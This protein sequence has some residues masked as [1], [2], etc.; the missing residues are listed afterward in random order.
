MKLLARISPL[1]AFRSLSRAIALAERRGRLVRALDEAWRRGADHLVLTGGVTEDRFD[2]RFRVV[3][4]RLDDGTPGQPGRIDW[5]AA[6]HVMI[7]SLTDAGFE[8]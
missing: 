1:R 2:P 5:Q 6:A 4:R 3:A 8:G 7:H